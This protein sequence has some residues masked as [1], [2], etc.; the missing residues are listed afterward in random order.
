MKQNICPLPD[1]REQTANVRGK[2]QKNSIAC[3]K[4]CYTNHNNR[5]HMEINRI[6]V[7]LW[8]NKIFIHN[9]VSQWTRFV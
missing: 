3:E 6:K 2:N 5:R 1:S 7:F 4:T 9:N 8:I